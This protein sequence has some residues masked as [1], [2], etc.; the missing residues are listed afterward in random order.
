MTL[1]QPA[2]V[3]PPGAPPAA[4]AT[5]A[6]PGAPPAAPATVAPP[7]APP[8]A[9]AT[10][11]PPGAPPAAPAAMVPAAMVP[12]ESVPAPAGG[13]SLRGLVYMAVSVVLLSSAWPLTKLAL[14]Q[15]TTPLWFAM[16]R[17][18]LSFLTALLLLVPRGMV[19]L[20]V[21]ADWPAT[22]AI[23][24]LQLGVFFALA[25]EAVDWVPAGRTA[26]LANTTT[27][28]VV[29]LSLVFLHE[30]IPLRRWLAAGLGILGI[31]V[32]MNP[33][34]IDWSARTVL[35]GHLFLLGAGLS[36]AI[37]IVVVRGFR[38]RQTML[39]LL[40]W[41]FLVGSLVLLP[42]VAWQAP[43]GHFAPGPVAWGSM[44][45]IGLLAGPVGTWCIIEATVLLPTMVTSVG[46]LATP[47][48]GLVLSNL[49]LGEPFT[50]DLLAG[51]VLILGGVGIAAW[52][53][54]RRHVPA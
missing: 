14:M 46:F 44:A 6:P 49:V 37:A 34:S 5:V 4:P 15:G 8:A 42:L 29:P 40:P 16:A 43:H 7:G 17:A 9:P 24:V 33:W 28:W 38:P 20:P 54:R 10:V 47:A 48:V 45:Y 11:A 50:P 32:L 12:A 3:A 26:I 13:L 31:L 18:V 36:W 39:V 2:T 1:V 51:S 19:R 35:I 41:C 53:A 30:A 23:G 27:I 22:L 21:R 52:P 25:H